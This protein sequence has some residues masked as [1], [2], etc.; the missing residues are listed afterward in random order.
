[1]GYGQLEVILKMA[2]TIHPQIESDRHFWNRLGKIAPTAS[3]DIRARS[4]AVAR[5]TWLWADRIGRL[6]SGKPR[7]LTNSDGSFGFNRRW[8]CTSSVYSRSSISFF[9]CDFSVS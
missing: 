7:R 2:Q 8:I 1:M 6:D 3:R 9:L 5:R 4:G